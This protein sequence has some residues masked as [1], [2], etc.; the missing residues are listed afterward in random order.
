MDGVF[1]T[2]NISKILIPNKNQLPPGPPPPPLN[3]ERNGGKI[4]K[5]P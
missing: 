2:T 5:N 3:G 4:E 1:R